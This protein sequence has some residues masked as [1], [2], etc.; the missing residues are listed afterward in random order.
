MDLLSLIHISFGLGAALFMLLFSYSSI[1]EHKIR[2]AGI[3][4]IF[5]AF[6]ILLWILC[7]RINN[8]IYILM[9]NS[10][11]ILFILLFFLPI[12]R[13]TIQKAEIITEK[14]DERDTMFARAKYIPG[15][16]RYEEYYKD[17]PKNK[18]IDDKCRKL[19][20]ILE[21][22]GKYYDSAKS[23]YVRSLFKIEEQ[24]VIYADGHVSNEKTVKTP[25]D[26][27][28]ILKEYALHLGAAEVGIARLNPKYLYSH[29]GIGPE[30]YGSEIV[31][32]H[33]YVIAYTLE[34][35]YDLVNRSPYVETTM[36]TANQYLNAQR[37][38][39]SLAQYIR[40]MGYS[41]RAHMSGSNY[42]MMLPP[43][44]YEAGLGEMSRM[45]YLIS[46]KFGA[47]IRLG[48]VSTELPLIHDNPVSFGVLDFCEI[49]RKCAFN[50]PSG[51]IPKNGKEIVRGIE[52]WQINIEKCYQYWRHAGTDCGICM[53]VCPFSHPHTFVH[54]VLKAGIKN[55]QIARHVSHIG[56]NIFYGGKI[57]Y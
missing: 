45:G 33:D 21:P 1:I 54:K 7:Y 22:G 53:R 24:N 57:K 56:D 20:P 40:D 31:N 41:A 46:K 10:L 47:R 18:K 25:D 48:A 27:S 30:E 14:V 11:F 39:I 9:L 29:V 36:E 2:A 32:N 37:I 26:F 5:L 28:K 52:K 55:S 19:P 42:Q 43:I 50:C 23:T 4:L 3:S 51:A 44:A 38:S 15:T 35:D 34:M 8:D 49:C 17:N 6:I 12:G 13:K 16:K